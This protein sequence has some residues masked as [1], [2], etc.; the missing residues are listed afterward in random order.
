VT[1]NH[2]DA[3]PEE[4]MKTPAT[5]AARWVAVAVALAL[6]LPTACSRD[7]RAAPAGDPCSR[8]DLSLLDQATVGAYAEAAAGLRARLA[9]IE[10]RV[11]HACDGMNAQL[12][13]PRPRNTYDA[14]ATFRAHVDE[15]RATGAQISLQVSRSCTIDGAARDR[16]QATC[17]LDGC[18]AAAC[19]DRAP[20]RDACAAVAEA[21]VQCSTETVAVTNDVDAE[22]ED[23]ITLNADEWGA[24][25]S[26]VAELQ[27]T[28]TELG[29]P[30]LAYSQTADVIGKDE[31][32][33]YQNALGDLGVALISFDA[34]RDGLASL[35]PLFS[36]ASH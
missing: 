17:Q 16:C 13:L 6:I 20:C 2:A 9:E 36:P 25:E 8:L 3:A 34:A 30:L 21:D 23:A 27:P 31:Q 5:R 33:C 10:G 19:P 32:D 1:G 24:L 26:L 28:V 29:P 15:A 35:P 7:R 14:C 4:G 11:F 22:L 12:A 18:N